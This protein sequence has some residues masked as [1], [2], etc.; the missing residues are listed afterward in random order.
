MA[1]I[2]ALSRNYFTRV[3][4][5]FGV[6][7]TTGPIL[8]SYHFWAMA[9]VLLN[10][11]TTGTTG[12]TRHANSIWICR[13]SSDGVGGGSPVSA[14][15]VAGTNRWWNAGVFPPAGLVR[16]TNAQNHHWMLLENVAFGQELLFNWTQNDGY[17]ALDLAPT[18]TFS[19][20]G[21]QAFPTA[22]SSNNVVTLA[23]TAYN[24]TDAG[25]YNGL[26][27][28]Y[29]TTGGVNYLHFTCSDTGEF[30]FTASRAGGTAFTSF[31]G[32]WR[33]TGQ[34]V[35]DLNN[36]FMFASNSVGNTGRGTPINGWVNGNGFVSSRGPNGV[37]TV[38]EGCLVEYINGSAYILSQGA[39]S[40]TSK[41]DVAP[42]QIA[43]TSPQRARRGSLIDVYIVAA[44][45]I[46]APIPAVGPT[47]ERII[48][49]DTMWPC[50]A[51]QPLL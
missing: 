23:K 48:I 6:N 22:N 26:F 18:G 50:I 39:D 29:G 36:L 9:H 34:N 14:V 51:V 19:G 45:T 12:G 35:G 49:G 3:N 11:L 13:G 21:A 44:D 43:C 32:V 25:Q 46:G 24:G 31:F 41:F 27:G 5:P 10:L 15:G 8:Q 30:Y 38:N 17:T 16:G 33:T 40:I 20:G 7:N 1:N 28:D 2:P 4:I 37:P 42:I 47:Q